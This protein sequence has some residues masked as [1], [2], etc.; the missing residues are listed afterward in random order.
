MK[1]PLSQSL[2]SLSSKILL[3]RSSSSPSF[4]APPRSRSF[5]DSSISSFPSG[6]KSLADLVTSNYFMRRG[7]SN[8][9][10]TVQGRSSS[11]PSSTSST[12]TSNGSLESLISSTHFVPQNK[13]SLLSLPS[14]RGSPPVR[15]TPSVPTNHLRSVPQS[16]QPSFRRILHI[17]NALQNLQL[18]FRRVF[19]RLRDIIVHGLPSDPNAWYKENLAKIEKKPLPLVYKEGMRLLVEKK[20]VSPADLMANP[21]SYFPKEDNLAKLQKLEGD[22][23]NKVRAAHLLTDFEWWALDR[24]LSIHKTS[25]KEGSLKLLNKVESHGHPLLN[26][27]SAELRNSRATIIARYKD[28]KIQEIHHRKNR[29]QEK[30]IVKTQNALEKMN[31]VFRRRA[32]IA[33]AKLKTQ[34]AKISLQNRTPLPA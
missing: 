6:K 29:K 14:G 30:Q 25:K 15:S 5:S 8:P 2:S 23:L 3:T 19:N 10:S 18:P 21:S 31:E 4:Q 34:E 12:S 32:S 13:R 1:S 17:P 7:T 27:A 20:D 11:S 28:P 26:D 33:L 9:A 22:L 16:T 24:V